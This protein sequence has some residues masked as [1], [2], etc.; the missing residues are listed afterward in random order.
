ML[1]TRDGSHV[2]VSSEWDNN[3]SFRVVVR[4]RDYPRTERSER[5]ARYLARR[6]V[7]K[8]EIV[9]WSRLDS[10]TFENGHLVYRFTVSRLERV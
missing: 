10:V 1:S 7:A 8:P 5:K 3:G 2:V 4:Q 6:A 9:K